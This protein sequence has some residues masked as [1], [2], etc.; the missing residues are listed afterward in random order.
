MAFFEPSHKTKEIS[1]INCISEPQNCQTRHNTNSLHNSSTRSH[2]LHQSRAMNR[3]SPKVTGVQILFAQ[4][5]RNSCPLPVFVTV[6][7]VTIVTS[8]EVRRIVLLVLIFSHFF[9][10]KKAIMIQ[11]QKKLEKWIFSGWFFSSSKKQSYR[12]GSNFLCL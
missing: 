6:V 8:V 4:F 3:I 1:A 9:P 11:S 12:C 2:K 10:S 7:I 5:T